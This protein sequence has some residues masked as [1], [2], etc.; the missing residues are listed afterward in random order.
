MLQLAYPIED[1]V[2]ID[3]IEH[4]IDM[5]FDNVLRL[6][7]MLSDEELSNAQKAEYG[8]KMLF[9]KDLSYD[10]E[11]KADIFI[12]VF[13]NKI[14]KGKKN[15]K[16][17]DLDGNPLPIE[18]GNDSEERQYCLKQDADYIYASFMSD[19]GIDLIEQQGKLHWYQFRALLSGLTEGS[20]FLR[21]IE[22]R[23]SELPKG[24]HAGKQRERMQK[25]KQA[26]SLD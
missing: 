1:S 20:K 8:I 4:E 19:Y 23:T 16:A 22:I 7:D 21:V 9:D 11:T 10:I 13:E 26:Y 15:N 12:E 18:E 17:V 5:S 24:K 25:L 14:G 3:G 6:I 2:I